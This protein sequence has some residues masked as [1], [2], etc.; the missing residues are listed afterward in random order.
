MIVLENVS[1]EYSNGVP[2]LNDINLNI[3][4]GEFV[5]IIGPTGCGKTYIFT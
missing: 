5:F 2:A 4:K 1:M 3:S